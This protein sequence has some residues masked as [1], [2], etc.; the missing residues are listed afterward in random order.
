MTDP[1]LT[2]WAYPAIVNRGSSP[3]HPYLVV[4]IMKR[5]D[6][7]AHPLNISSGSFFGNQKELAF[8]DLELSGHFADIGDQGLVAFSPKYFMPYD[9]NL[10][11]AKAMVKT[12]AKI[13]R[14]LSKSEAQEHGDVF[15]SFCKAL[16]LDGAVIHVSGNPSGMLAD[17]KWVFASIAGGREYL[18]AL[19]EKQLKKAA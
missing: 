4:R 6:D 18:R 2:Y 15:L 3:G 10:R 8:A 11:H 14:H 12:L 13:D 16:G 7:A 17:S 9:I 1:K 5:E 19:I